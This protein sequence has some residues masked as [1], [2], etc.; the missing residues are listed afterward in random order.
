MVARATRVLLSIYDHTNAFVAKQR[1]L[2]QKPVKMG[3]LRKWRKRADSRAKTDKKQ[4][5]TKTSEMRTAS[6]PADHRQTALQ[7]IDFASPVFWHFLTPLNDG[8]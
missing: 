5:L 2:G 4:R 1:I 6:Q 7:S 8:V 3:D